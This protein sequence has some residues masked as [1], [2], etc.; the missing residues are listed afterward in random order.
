MEYNRNK[1]DH[2]CFAAQSSSIFVELMLPLRWPCFEMNNYFSSPTWTG[3]DLDLFKKK[4][5]PITVIARLNVNP[6]NASTG[7]LRL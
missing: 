5:R 6:I 1:K 2:I 4:N 7:S 3:L